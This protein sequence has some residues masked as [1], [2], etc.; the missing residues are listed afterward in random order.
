MLKLKGF[1]SR[2]MEIYYHWNT[3][4]KGR[5]RTVKTFSMSFRAVYFIKDMSLIIDLRII[6]QFF[7]SLLS[8]TIKVYSRNVL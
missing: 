6:C 1:L 5:Q 4:E 2:T 3:A 8:R 7:S